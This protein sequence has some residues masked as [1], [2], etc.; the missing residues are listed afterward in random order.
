MSTKVN[1]LAVSRPLFVAGGFLASTLFFLL[2][3]TKT[4]GPGSTS[5]V[6]FW[7]VVAV[8]GGPL[9]GNFIWRQLMKR[10]F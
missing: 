4:D 5:M 9:L 7:L 8:A 3:L 1:E 2:A 10:K 6:F